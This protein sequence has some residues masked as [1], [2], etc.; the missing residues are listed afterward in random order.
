MAAPLALAGL[1][2]PGVMGVSGGPWGVW[3]T[4]NLDRDQVLWQPYLALDEQEDPHI[5]YTKRP[6]DGAP[7]GTFY[8]RRE[9]LQWV[10][11]RVTTHLEAR[12]FGLDQDGR[13]HLLFTNSTGFYYATLLGGKL[14]PL[15]KLDTF[16]VQYSDLKV[17]HLGNP[18]ILFAAQ[19]L[20]YGHRTSD[21]QWHIEPVSPSGYLFISLALDQDARPHIAYYYSGDFRSFRYATKTV[22]GTWL[23]E[24]NIPGAGYHYHAITVDTKGHPHVASRHDQGGLK[25]SW[26]D[27]QGWHTETVDPFNANGFWPSIRVDTQGGVHIVARPTALLSATALTSAQLKYY[28][29]FPAITPWYRETVDNVGN[30]NGHLPTLVL[31]GED[32]PR[33]SY[34]LVHWRYDGPATQ[35]G[36]LNPRYDLMYAEPAAAKLLPPVEALLLREALA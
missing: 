21:G 27:E 19:G 7:W 16:P 35:E 9:G 24:E 26:R 29:K 36:P 25:H 5:V 18:H 10:T 34:L 11:E 30:W 15:L 33:V 31:D 1:A 6:L 2:P 32:R 28:V 23:I 3:V 4:E 13:G 12:G 14:S 8:T 17:D 20:K 22:Q